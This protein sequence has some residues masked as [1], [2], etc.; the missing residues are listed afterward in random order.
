MIFVFP[1]TSNSK[2]NITPLTVN[3]TKRA[4]Q[5]PL[6]TYL[7]VSRDNIPDNSTPLLRN[8]IFLDRIRITPWG[9]MLVT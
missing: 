8:Q 2:L 6:A 5:I 3:R 7:L 9:K 1:V 4:S